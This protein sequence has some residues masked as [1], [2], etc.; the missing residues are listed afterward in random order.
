MRKTSILLLYWGRRGLTQFTLEAARAALASD[1]LKTSI[2]VSR[3]N[4]AF[5][6]FEVFGPSLFPVETFASS[7]GAVGNTWRI[8]VLR[9]QLS[10][11]LRQNRVEAVV[12]LMPHVWS[13]AIAPVIRASGARFSTLVHDATPHAGDY[14]SRIAHFLLKRPAATADKIITLSDAVTKE[15]LTRGGMNP[16]KV[17]TLFHPQLSYTLPKRRVMPSPG[18]PLRLIF[19]GRIMAYKGLPLFLD[20]LEVL[21]ARSIPF[22]A[23]VYG[24]GQLGDLGPHLRSLGVDVINRWLS[25]EEIGAVLL[26]SHA[27]LLT[28]TGASQSGVAASAVGA[29]V[30]VVVTPVGGLIAQIR[31]G[32]DGIVATRTEATAVADAVER[33][34]IPENYARICDALATSNA[35]RSMP[36]FIHQAVEATLRR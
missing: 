33:L 17:V 35:N 26:R 24:E 27:V 22:E 18:A 36:A 10:E 20:T 6:E 15:V 4:E 21:R 29:G 9:R 34:F 7:A 8:P 12:E 3:Q 30:P 14:R 13:A 11:H 1:T 32:I 16:K 5:G 19:L 31:D 25:A 28:H 23:G 2:S